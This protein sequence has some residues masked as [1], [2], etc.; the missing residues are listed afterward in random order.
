VAPGGSDVEDAL[1]DIV[2]GWEDWDTADNPLADTAY[3]QRYEGTDKAVRQDSIYGPPDD[4]QA[5]YRSWQAAETDTDR[6]NDSADEDDTVYDADYRV[7]IPPY[8]PLED[9]ESEGDRSA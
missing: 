3:S 5:D 2:D 1:D 7:I 6:E 4:V 8:R 9:A